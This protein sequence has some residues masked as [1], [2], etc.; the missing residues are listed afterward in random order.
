MFD[1]ESMSPDEWQFIRSYCAS[2]QRH[3][4]LIQLVRVLMNPDWLGVKCPII[5]SRL[6]NSLCDLQQDFN[7]KIEQ[8]GQKKKNVKPDKGVKPEQIAEVFTLSF[9]KIVD[10]LTKKVFLTDKGVP[11]HD[12]W[13]SGHP[14]D[15]QYTVKS[16]QEIYEQKVSQNDAPGGLLLQ[17]LLK[18]FSALPSKNWIEDSGEEAYEEE[19]YEEYDE[20]DD[21]DD[22]PMSFFM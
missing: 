12:G 17:A 14:T 16:L 9:F 20:D 13:S 7:T 19:E 21:Y 3:Y 4:E 6:A 8:L 2:V 1:K 5:A 11:K 18:I 15:W 22:D 10:P